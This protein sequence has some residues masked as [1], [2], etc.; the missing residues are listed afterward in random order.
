LHPHARWPVEGACPV[1]CCGR[2]GDG[3]LIVAD[4]EEF[5]ARIIF[6]PG[7]RRGDP[8]PAR[9]FCGGGTIRRGMRRARSY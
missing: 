5:F 2:K 1:T 7:E 3:L 9:Y 6:R 8:T 4:L